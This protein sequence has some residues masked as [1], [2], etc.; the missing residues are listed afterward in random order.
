MRRSKQPALRLLPAALLLLLAAWP[1]TGCQGAGSTT[2]ENV[3]ADWYVLYFTTPLDPGTSADRGSGIDRNL[4][5]LIDSAQESVDVAA[6][7]LDLQSLADALIRAHQAGIAVRLVTDESNADEEAVTRLRQ[8]GIPVVARPDTGWGIMHNKFVIV[9]R[10]WVWTG[11]WNL[12][13]NCTYRNNNN[14]IVIASRALALD[15][16]TEF[17]ELFAAQFGPASPANTPH[18]RLRFERA[19]QSAEVEVYFA[20][21]DDVEAHLLRTL[22]SAR[23]SVRFMAFVFTSAPLAD[24]LIDLAG[25]GVTVQGVIESRS[26]GEPASQHER[27]RAGGVHV[28]Q[29]GNP[30][31]MHHKV[32]IVD[33]QVVVMGSYNFTASANEQND[34][35]LLIIHDPQVAAAFLAEFGRVL[36]EA[37]TAAP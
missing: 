7:D 35:N 22:A 26:L 24:A 23:S 19:G 37:Q 10:Q 14:A 27:L 18:P 1:L 6:Y 8:A 3:D 36:Q 4:V 25:R 30:Y 9:D 21:E 13:Y 11:S 2:V 34:E 31:V 29:D 16:T 32:M 28:F 17:E 5:A 15:Y 12:T 33:D 20:P